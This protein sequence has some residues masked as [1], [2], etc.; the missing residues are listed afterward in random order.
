[1]SQDPQGE[2]NRVVACLVL[3]GYLL[4]GMVKEDNLGE[5]HFFFSG[6]QLGFVQNEGQ[7]PQYH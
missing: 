6:T 1:M 2:T 3:D 5:F 7:N 4:I